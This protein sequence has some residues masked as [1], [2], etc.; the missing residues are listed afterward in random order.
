MRSDQGRFGIARGRVARTVLALLSTAAALWVPEAS[1]YPS[2]RI[3]AG[4][5]FLKL[6][7][8]TQTVVVWEAFNHARGGQFLLLRGSETGELQVAAILP[9]LEGPHRYRFV[10]HELPA[11]IETV[12]QLVYRGSQ[13]AE[14]VLVTAHVERPELSPTSLGPTPARDADPGRG[15]EPRY[16]LPSPALDRLAPA[17]GHEGGDRPEPPSPPPKAS[18]PS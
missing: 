17:A 16:P 18:S 5:H 8:S 12:Y 11:G 3:P 1:G 15:V 14:L 6:G 10:D 13:G 7:S 2:R 4:R 9:A